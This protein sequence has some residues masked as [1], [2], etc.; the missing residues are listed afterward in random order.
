M[1]SAAVTSTTTIPLVQSILDQPDHFGDSKVKFE[2][3]RPKYTVNN[4]LQSPSGFTDYTIQEM[5]AMTKMKTQLA[6]VYEEDGFTQLDPKPVEYAANLQKTGGV[7][8]QIFGVSNLQLGQITDLGI[9][10]DRTVPMA[11]YIA[12]N[13]STM[14]FPYWRQDINWSWRGENASAG[15]F[16]A[17]YQADV[18]IVAAELNALADAQ[19]IATLAKGLQRLG[20]PKFVLLLN[21]VEV[22]RD[23]LREAGVQ[24]GDFK[25][26]LRVID[27]LKP[28]NESDVIDELVQVVN[29]TKEKAAALLK[30]MSYKGPISSFNF[31][32]KPSDEGIAGLK[33]LQEIEASAIELGVNPEMLEFAP[34]LARGLDYYTGVVFETF[35][36]GKEKYGSIAS[37]G[38]YDDLISE[39]NPNVKLKGV[40][41][42]IG[43]TRLFAVMVQEGLV[44]L[45]KQTSAQVFVGYRSNTE[46]KTALAAATALRKLGISVELNIAKQKSTKQIALADEKGIPVGLFIQ[47]KEG[48]PVESNGKKLYP[49]FVKDMRNKKSSDKQTDQIDCTTLSEALTAIRS[50]V[51][52]SPR[53]AA[54][55]EKA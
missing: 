30:A 42:S 22:A 50:L 15:R 52:P 10:F 18:D 36:P 45:T 6:A 17:F 4:P 21:H 31:P 48:E 43:L 54:D 53:Y 24:P 23:F 44:D 19:C 55:E 40:G 12:K 7:T 39:F 34:S 47:D 27:K 9:P 26:A 33:H 14:K 3:G 46:R 1:S 37:G 38:R 35:M 8:K 32:H 29:L 16:R 25:N 28:N 13:H 41:G 5:Q 20:V 11:I 2:N 49:I 51:N